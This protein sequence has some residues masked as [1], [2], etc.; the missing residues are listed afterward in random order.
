MFPAWHPADVTGG[1]VQRTVK[2]EALAVIDTFILGEEVL[3]ILV[4]VGD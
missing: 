3:E 4:G 1:T 2:G